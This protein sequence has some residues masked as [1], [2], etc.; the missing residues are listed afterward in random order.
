M[1]NF[2]KCSEDKFPDRCN[3]FRKLNNEYI[4]KKDYFKANN[5]WNVFK[6]NTMNDHHD[7]HLKTHLLLLLTS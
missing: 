4:T 7:L 2:K 5:I 1:D 3:F 6:M